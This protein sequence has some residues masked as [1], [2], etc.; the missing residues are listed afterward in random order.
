MINS[1]SSDYGPIYKTL[2][3]HL[4][5]G[6]LM[7]NAKKLPFDDLPY[8]QRDNFCHTSGD[9]KVRIAVGFWTN[10]D[11]NLF[12]WSVKGHKCEDIFSDEE[13]CRQNCKEWLLEHRVPQAIEWLKTEQ[14][15]L[16]EAQ[17]NG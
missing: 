4:F 11:E 5:D 10:D 8:L 6:T 16:R 14:K 13:E 2:G 15:R 12:S 1:F 7:T 9:Y 3:I 17:S